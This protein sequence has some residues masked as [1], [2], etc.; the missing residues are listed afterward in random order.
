MAAPSRSRELASFLAGLRLSD[1][2]SEAVRLLKLC[3]LD[4][5]GCA[6]GA[7]DTE[8]GRAAI[9][10]AHLNAGGPCTG[11]GSVARAR[12]ESAAPAHRAL[13]HPPTFDDLHRHAK[14]HPGVARIP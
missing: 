1:L 12:P 11:I 3:V 9:R 4:H 10:A 7:L 5:F 2:P 8:V 14:P 13:A 6:I